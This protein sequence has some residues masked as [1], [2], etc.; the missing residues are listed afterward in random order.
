MCLLAPCAP[1]VLPAVTQRQEEGERGSKYLS[2]ASSSPT[3]PPRALSAASSPHKGP[4]ANTRGCCPGWGRAGTGVPKELWGLWA[5]GRDFSG[6]GSFGTKLLMP[7]DWHLDS[8]VGSF[9]Q[10]NF[11]CHQA[12]A[13]SHPRGGCILVLGQGTHAMSKRLQEALQP[14]NP[15]LSAPPGMSW[16]P[17]ALTLPRD[18]R[19]GCACPWLL[20][21]LR[22]HVSPCQSLQGS[23]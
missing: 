8:A 19:K 15:R 13:G 21:A 3:P 9:P 20:P 1:S 16:Q 6:S 10:H 4:S 2:D 18:S 5:V 14:C 12:A 23:E 7:W 22:H 11:V 17:V